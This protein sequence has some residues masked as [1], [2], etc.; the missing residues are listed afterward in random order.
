MK[1]TSTICSEILSEL[2]KLGA[3]LN[4]HRVQLRVNPDVARAL[5]A[6]ERGGLKAIERSLGKAITLR[7]DAIL[8]HEQFDVMAM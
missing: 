7:S 4:G 2:Q 5:K 8:H 1:S 6:E 3:D